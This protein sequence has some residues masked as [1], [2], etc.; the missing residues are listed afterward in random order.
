[1][2]PVCIE[3][4]FSAISDNPGTSQTAKIQTGSQKH[5]HTHTKIDTPIRAAQSYQQ[6][7]STT[8]RRQM[9]V[10]SR[11]HYLGQSIDCKKTK[12]QP[13]LHRWRLTYSLL[14]HGL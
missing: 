10:L 12:L 1:M 9:H 6:H 3:V 7:L 14:G 11:V 4:P 5:T 13:V 2:Y 8:T